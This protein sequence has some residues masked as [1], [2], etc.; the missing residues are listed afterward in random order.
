MKK[1]IILIIALMPMLS[2][3]QK[4][5]KDIQKTTFEVEGFVECAKLVLKNKRTLL[6]V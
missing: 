1:I 6:K 2:F 3:A 4:A 5:K